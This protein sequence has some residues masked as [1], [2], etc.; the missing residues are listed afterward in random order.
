MKLNSD[1]LIKD[2]LGG[3]ISLKLREG[4]SL[5]DYCFKHIDGYDPDRFEALAIRVFFGKETI[6]TVY[7]LDKN[8]QENTVSAEKMPVRKFKMDGSF[9][10]D[11]I[12]FIEACN[13][14]LTTGNYPLEDMKVINE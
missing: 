5:N 11:I 10:K 9:L 4:G 7:A 3:V 6:I 1:T 8:A 2:D 13:F 12:P 14:T